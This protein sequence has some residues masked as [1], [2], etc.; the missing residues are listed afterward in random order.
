MESVIVYLAVTAAGILFLNGI[1]RA[2]YPE[3]PQQERANGTDALKKHL[4]TLEGCTCAAD[5]LP[6]MESYY[7]QK[8]GPEMQ[9]KFPTLEALN[10]ELAKT[11]TVKMMD[12]LAAESAKYREQAQNRLTIRATSSDFKELQEL[13]EGCD[14]DEGRIQVIKDYQIK[15][16][17]VPQL[18]EMCS[19]FDYDEGRVHAIELLRP[20]VAS[21]GSAHGLAD[22]LET[23]D[24]DEGKTKA[25]R[26]LRS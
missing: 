24:Y 11:S 23:F 9:K 22:V 26:K 5:G 2:A 4:Q 15:S 10:A 13:V 8:H 1:Y 19:A 14:F 16:V 21:S 25:L 20:V 18:A 17:T 3:K 12:G 6:T 7:C